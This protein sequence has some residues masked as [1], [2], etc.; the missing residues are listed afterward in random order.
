MGFR[1][2]TLINV[3]LIDKPVVC[4]ELYMYADVTEKIIV[5]SMK[6]HR[7]LGNGFQ[8]VIYQRCLEIELKIVAQCTPSKT[9]YK[10]IN[11]K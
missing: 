8:E 1:D 11:L 10:S 5:A 6:I 9:I 7:Y 3:A 2:V 4:Y